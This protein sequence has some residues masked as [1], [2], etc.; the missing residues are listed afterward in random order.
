MNIPLITDNVY[1]FY[2]IFGLTL[3]S[4][5]VLGAVQYHNST[6]ELVHNLA[7]S[8]DRLVKNIGDDASNLAEYGV[9]L[10]RINVIKSDRK[11]ANYFL[12]GVIGIGGLLSSYGFKK[13]Q[14]EVQVVDDELKRLQ[15]KQLKQ[16]V[17]EGDGE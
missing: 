15:V 10:A 3:V 16:L 2:A 17:G 12:G 1:K 5:S 4:V 13:W 6:N 11:L 7:K 8:H 9:V 14:S